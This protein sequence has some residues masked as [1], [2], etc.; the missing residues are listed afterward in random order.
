MQILAFIQQQLVL[1]AFLR[2]LYEYSAC[3]SQVSEEDVSRY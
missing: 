3:Q 1:T 2:Y